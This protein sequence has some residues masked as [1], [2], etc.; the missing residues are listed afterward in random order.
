[1]H[2]LR[3]WSLAYAP[4]TRGNLQKMQEIHRINAEMWYY[5]SQAMWKRILFG[6]ALWFFVNKIAK[7]RY[8]NNGPKDSHDGTLRDVSAMM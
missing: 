6:I 4:T 7:H 5:V 3:V 1:M 8:M 2:D